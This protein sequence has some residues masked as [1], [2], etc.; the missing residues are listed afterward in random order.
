MGDEH[1]TGSSNGPSTSLSALRSGDEGIISEIGGT[2]PTATRFREM[3]LAPGVRVRLLRAGT[4]IVVQ[5]EDGRLCLRSKD[6]KTIR[7]GAVN[8]KAP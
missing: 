1:A 3:G 5:A 7:V 6:A 8:G 2:A 4:P